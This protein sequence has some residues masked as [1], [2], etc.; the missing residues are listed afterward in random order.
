MMM[1]SSVHILAEDMNHAD[2][3]KMDEIQL[4]S[5]GTIASSSLAYGDRLAP[6]TSMNGTVKED[7]YHFYHICIV[8]HEHEHRIDV[9][10]KCIDGN[11]NLYMS[12]EEKYPRMGHSSWISQHFGDDH[13]KLFTYLDGFPRKYEDKNR[14]IS[15]HIGVFG[16]TKAQYN[17]TVSVTD[18][19]VTEEIH[20]LEEFYT[21]R[22]VE[23]RKSFG[24]RSLR[25]IK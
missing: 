8:R 22:H 24:G 1:T 11:A 20:K 9:D 7:E 19:P 10:L 17:L 13:V 15:L 5:D 2:P 12:S 4:S 21:K 3:C 18:L 6:N 16:Y 25:G 23:D 14:A